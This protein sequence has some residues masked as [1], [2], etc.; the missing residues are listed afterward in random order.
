MQANKNLS[1]YFSGNTSSP[2]YLSFPGR[3]DNVRI[4]GF[5]KGTW[6]EFK[7]VNELVNERNKINSA[8]EKELLQKKQQKLASSGGPKITKQTV[9]KDEKI[10]NYIFEDPYDK[11]GSIDGQFFP[12]YYPKGKK[13]EVNTVWG[14]V[15]FTPF[16]NQ[17]I[18]AF[19]EDQ[20]PGSTDT[21]IPIAAKTKNGLVLVIVFD[22]NGNI[23]IITPSKQYNKNQICDKIVKHLNLDSMGD[24]DDDW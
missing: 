18:S 1:F 13:L 19:L 3:G 9:I 12:S 22:S 6:A 23:L 10:D 4:K 11:V 15:S 14:P 24:D 5:D 7:K 2:A 21:Q 17:R 8:K 16:Y 20:M